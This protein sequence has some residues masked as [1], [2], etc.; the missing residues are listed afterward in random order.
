[1]SCKFIHHPELWK[2]IWLKQHNVFFYV[3]YVTFCPLLLKMTRYILRNNCH[4]YVYIDL[5][6]KYFKKPQVLFQRDKFSNSKVTVRTKNIYF[7][8]IQSFFI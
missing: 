2:N 6:G 8:L 5:F 3:T 7:K 1:M 4:A